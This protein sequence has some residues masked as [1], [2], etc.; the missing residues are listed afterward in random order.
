MKKLAMIIAM[1]AIAAATHAAD[2]AQMAK[3]NVS[4]AACHG[5]GA[6]GAPK[7]GDEA[8]WAPRMEKGMDILVAAV[9]DGM[10]AMP[11]KGL[12]NDCSA[13]DYKALIQYMAAPQ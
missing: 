5:T 1:W 12:C 7:T 11:P 13:D 4:C 10:G 8:D 6:A 3:Y 2:D 9:T